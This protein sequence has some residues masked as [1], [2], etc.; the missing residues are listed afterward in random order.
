ML[1]IQ[2][3]LVSTDLFEKNFVCNLQACKGACCIEGDEGAPLA[4]EEKAILDRVS[5]QVAG[6]LDEES[7]TLLE[8]H[9]YVK[10]ERGS[11]ATPLRADGA[12]IY[13]LR[14]GTGILSCALETA[15]R[16][17]KTDWIKPLSCHLYPV[18]IRED[19]VLGW[20]ALN[21]D[22]WSICAPACTN[23]DQLGVPVYRFVRNALIRKYGEAF[24]EELDEIA[25]NWK[26]ET[27]SKK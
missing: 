5:S 15:Y 17:G 21:Y 9:R 12:C 16:F 14:D 8:K 19:K 3:K 11:Y 10:L 18:R 24:Y 7:R 20:E 13:A 6:F 23:G 22:Q 1:E 2:G 27:N 25:Q 26:P 4:E